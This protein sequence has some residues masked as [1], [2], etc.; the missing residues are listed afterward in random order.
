MSER[1]EERKGGRKG[2]R[3]GERESKRARASERT[4]VGECVLARAR[5]RERKNES[6]DPCG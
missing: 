6:R 1:D 2:G 4:G 5:V 3:E